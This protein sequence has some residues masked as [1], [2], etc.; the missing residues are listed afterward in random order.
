MIRV[1]GHETYGVLLVFLVGCKAIESP[2]AFQQLGWKVLVLVQKIEA[3][4]QLSRL[5]G[6][7]MH[8]QVGGVLTK[9]STRVSLTFRRVRDPGLACACDFEESC[10][11]VKPVA[12]ATFLKKGV[13]GGMADEGTTTIG[14]GR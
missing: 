3:P 12:T 6:V 8:P 5:S 13:D 14:A 9:R 7:A 4:P 11:R 1:V 10:D 2:P